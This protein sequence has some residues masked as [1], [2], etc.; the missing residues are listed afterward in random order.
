[1][2]IGHPIAW[3]DG[4]P[5]FVTYLLA[6]ALSCPVP[7]AVIG[8]V[9]TGVVISLLVRSRFATWS[10]TVVLVVVVAS[11]AALAV[12][13]DEHGV[14][15]LVGLAVALLGGLVTRRRPWIS[16]RSGALR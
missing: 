12:V 9:A 2:A 1:M 11:S 8:S 10:L 13:R 4:W 6:L 14:A 5:D 3:R 7:A 15:V 16:G